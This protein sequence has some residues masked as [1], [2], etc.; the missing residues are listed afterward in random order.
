GAGGA[1]GGAAAPADL[2]DRLPLEGVLD[3]DPPAA[4][5]PD[6]AAG[7]DREAPEI[8]AVEDRGRPVDRPALD[9]AGRVD[10]VRGAASRV[11]V[12]AGLLPQPLA[13]R[14]HAPHLDVGVIDRELAAANAANLAL[15]LERAEGR[16]DPD[17]PVV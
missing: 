16:V 2:G 13:A 12:A 8:G 3:A 6:V 1:C 5:G 14:E 9:Q 15:R 11:E 7:V 4:P 17:Q 10:A